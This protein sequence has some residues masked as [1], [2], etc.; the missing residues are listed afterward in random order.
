MS[1]TFSFVCKE[2]KLKIWV[3]QGWGSMT[4]FYSGMPEVMLRLVR[5]LAMTLGKPVMLLCNDTQGE[6]F[7][8]CEEF[9]DTDDEPFEGPNVMSP[10][11]TTAT[12]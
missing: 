9:E 3:G 11:T 7:E 4:N 10:S 1:Q 8:D 12:C 5:F 2:A 6:Q